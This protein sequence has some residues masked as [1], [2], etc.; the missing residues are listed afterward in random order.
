MVSQLRVEPRTCRLRAIG[1]LSNR[2]RVVPSLWNFSKPLP[3]ACLGT[4]LSVHDHELRPAGKGRGN[5]QQG[6]AA[7]DPL[8][9]PARRVF[10]LNNALNDVRF[11]KRTREEKGPLAFG[12]GAPFPLFD[13][14]MAEAR[15]MDI[16][17]QTTLRNADYPAYVEL[18]V[19]R[20][21]KL[22]RP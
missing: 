19:V 21:V 22:S 6:V 17:S 1:T 16:A 8:G 18:S 15:Q 10:Q 5:R 9:A 3:S 4:R 11:R 14:G 2:V 13:V 20:R 12:L 7:H